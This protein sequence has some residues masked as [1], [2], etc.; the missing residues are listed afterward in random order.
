MPSRPL[1]S[2]ALL[3][4]ALLSG[5][6]L[7]AALLA[8]PAEAQRLRADGPPVRLDVGVAPAA[9]PLFSPDGA[10]VAFSRPD[11][12][13]LWVA[14]AAGGAAR[15]LTGAPG[16]R[17]GAAFS[18]DGARLVARTSRY[19]GPTRY[20]AVTVFDVA[21][22]TAEPLTDERTHL[23]DLPR[24]ADAAHVVLRQ[25]GAAQVFPVAGG[26]APPSAV[27]FAPVPGGFARLEAATGRAET[28]R[29]AVPGLEPDA[30]LLNLTVSPDGER[31]A[32]E[33]LG[34]GL[35]VCRTD[36]SEVR[37][38]G[39]GE[40]PAW[41]PDGRWLA[42]MLTE[43]DGHHLTGADLYAVSAD[44]AQRVRLT[45]TPDRLEMNPAWSPDGRFVAYDDAADGA[46]YL[47]PVRE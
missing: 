33:V 8:A 5:A 21:S 44:G 19:D 40:R 11:Y 6:L 16:A 12:A 31:V 43:D 18:P 38:L 17:F 39:R 29:P 4:G 25:D 7:V 1:L 22:G 46:L 3:S 35:Y 15:R 14:P 10:Y 34:D 47:L 24:W 2:G 26:L 28:I 9:H 13:G 27:A 37:A 42:V 30:M 41:S 32:F 36:G 20:L 45:A 23:P